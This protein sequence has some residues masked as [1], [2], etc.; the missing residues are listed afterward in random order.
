MANKK[1]YEIIINGVTE[2]TK[3]VET[4][5]DALNK[6]STTVETHSKSIKQSSS[7]M[8]ELAKTEKK[9][10][11]YS[12][13]YNKALQ[14]NK[15]VL[16]D[17]NKAIK[18]ELELEK[19]NLTV[20][21][22]IQGSYR[23]KQQLLTALGKVIK[24]TN[25][26][27]D[28]E[29]EKLNQLKTQ[30]VSINQ[31]LKTFDAELGN[32][33]RN[34]GNY[35]S[36]LKDLKAKLKEGTAE[37]AVM[38]TQ[39]IKETDEAF[40]KLAKEVGKTQDAIEDARA[41]IK[42]EASDTKALDDVINLAQSATAAFQLWKG[43]MTAFGIE[44]EEATKT[45]QELMSVMSMVQG[46]QTFSKTL[47]SGTATS[48]MLS[49]ASK[50]LKLDLI[51][52]DAAAMK[53]AV[54]QEG[55][56]V[57]QKAG[58][59]ATKTLS[60]AIKAI[61]LMFV[62]GLVTELVMHWEDL[63]GWFDKT[64]PSL[65]KVGGVMNALK[66][67]VM[68]LGKAIINWCVN[69]LKMMSD[70]ISKIMKG[71]F[72]GAMNAAMEGIKNQFAGTARAFKEGF[73]EQVERGLEEISLKQLEET[74]KQT[75]YHLDMLK[76]QKGNQAKYSKEGIELQ[77]KDFEERR[78][79]AKDNQEKLRAIDIEE[80]NFHR[81][82]EEQKTK[83]TEAALKKRQ[84]AAKKAADEE[85]KRKAQEEKEEKE[86]LAREKERY[87]NEV[88]SHQKL[89]DSKYA[90]EKGIFEKSRTVIPN[91][92]IDFTKGETDVK[93]LD[94]VIDV[95][96]NQLIYQTSRLQWGKILGD[97]TDEQIADYE[98]GLARLGKAYEKL[99]ILQGEKDKSKIAEFV[100]EEDLKDINQLVTELVT[101]TSTQER[102]GGYI[103]TTNDN[104]NNFRSNVSD[105]A[106]SVEAYFTDMTKLV[107]LIESLEQQGVKVTE[108]KIKELSQFSNIFK[109]IPN[110]KLE[111]FIGLVYD[112]RKAIN[113]AVTANEKM[114]E[115]NEAIQNTIENADKEIKR[116]VDDVED[117]YK[118]LYT[119]M[120]DYNVKRFDNV[121]GRM[122][123]K[124]TYGKYLRDMGMGWHQVYESAKEAVEKTE[125]IWNVKLKS[126][127]AKY[128]ENSIEY[129]NAVREM[130]A[131]MRKLIAIQEEAAAKMPGGGQE[132]GS[133]ATG[134]TQSPSGSK[135]KSPF[136]NEDGSTNWD[137]FLKGDLSE[138]I[139][140]VTDALFDNLFDPIAD[141]FSTLLEFQIEEAQEALDR[142]TEMH[143]KSVDAIASSKDRLNEISEEMKSAN[144]A[145]L[146]SL[147]EKQADE[148]LLLA[149]R[150]AE[151]K[152]LAK[153]KEKRE[154]EL[155][156]KQKQQKKLD[157]RMQLLQA[158][159]NTALGA[160]KAYS[161]YGWPL[162]AVFAAIIASM[163]AI[164]V[165]T[166]QKQL[167]KMADG[168]LL[169]GRS[170][171]NGGMRI[172][173]TNIEVEGGEYVVNKRSTMRYL[174]LLEAINEEGRSRK[175]AS[176]QLMRYASGGELNYQ[177]ID[178]NLGMLDTN[179]VIQSSIGELDI[180]PVVSVVDINKGQKNLTQ[181]RQMAGSTRR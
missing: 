174:P 73:Q 68:G 176:H 153:E 35:S 180:H 122:V 105:A 26:Q 24:N 27:T 54:S 92:I 16:A 128:G 62:I 102:L 67:V 37:L 140:K 137:E 39:G 129:I 38:R 77:K 114:A 34:V 19:A 139:G 123:Y 127:A 66:G 165:A 59:V 2:A 7:S 18:E 85:K 136:I 90:Y 17:K 110:E 179:K 103:K 87:E 175:I 178:S 86:R 6:L 95:I 29:K 117:S 159:S 65:K 4:L 33:Q 126:I 31:E 120:K 111:Y 25:A 49:K 141:A 162:G 143:D 154:Q 172:Q 71:D 81:E 10:T 148:M 131:E 118:M 157:M 74:N 58:T 125:K 133:T 63:V 168:G 158:V 47:Q 41:A 70:V 150:E 107:K 144:A 84:A 78:K 42:R 134:D 115:E 149:Q 30:Y 46:L 151:E 109:N 91:L 51:A 50:L 60:M 14:A 75:K 22:N 121:I 138:V 108:G 96:Q 80:A 89:V 163:G 32:H 79:L 45:I 11:E 112:W 76:A 21:E 48:M 55:L 83:A 167:S 132:S 155:E 104:F 28:E 94:A 20:Q 53:A 142:A 147:K 101:V 124:N 170:H 135:R 13:E 98:K 52:Q 72:Q 15:A 119:I 146:A 57:A 99:V 173:G 43:A 3:K 8:D 44:N 161:Q 61:P 12:N 40:Q 82:C 5:G 36:A 100:T 164:Q 166:I 106:I 1:E 145:E 130:E 152:R 169:K 156:K 177:K 116:Y 56:T 69:P 171:A 64:F 181:V 88:K 93:G 9:I 23:E 97:L 160:T 113:D